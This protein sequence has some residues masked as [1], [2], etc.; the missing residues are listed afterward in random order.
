M[1]EWSLRL[2]PPRE[3]RRGTHQRTCSRTDTTPAPQMAP[4]RVTRMS[5]LDLPYE[6]Q[7]FVLAFLDAKSLSRVA[8]TCTELFRNQT[9]QVVDALCMHAA[10]HHCVC[11]DRL[12]NALTSWSSYLAFI[13]CRQSEAWV[14]VATG[15]SS[16]FFVTAGGCLSSCGSESA[17]ELGA[18]GHGETDAVG[19]M[20]MM[21]VLNSPTPLPSMIGIRIN[22]VSTGSGFCVAVSRCGIV[23][24][25]GNGSYGCLGH[26]DTNNEPSP[27][28]VQ[29]L[30]STGTRVLSVA[31]GHFHCLAITEG[32][33]VFSWGQ[34]QFGRCGY[35]VSS[36]GEHGNQS[37]QSRPRCVD[38]LIAVKARAAAAFDYHS[39]VVTELGALYTFGSGA[40][41]VDS[42]HVR[43]HHELPPTR[44]IA[45]RHVHITAAATG[46]KHALA[47]ANDGI[48]F[49]WG[50]N[51]H[52][53]LGTG[54]FGIGDSMPK[55]VVAMHGIAVV[56]ISTG[57][58]SSYAVDSNGELFTWGKGESG[59]LGHGESTNSCTPR[60]VDA[61]RGM[62]VVAVSPGQRNTTVTVMRDG[63]VFGWGAAIGFFL[64][65]IPFYNA[66]GAM[67]STLPCRYRRLTLL[68]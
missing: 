46:G 41:G 39:L 21:R 51:L 28:E 38:A 44:V 27:R 35:R 65:D 55:V 14:P 29:Y 37:V 4:D 67:C 56:S 17:A 10:V 1:Q 45:L 50:C 66:Y 32:G 33:A 9:N 34:S 42:K 63:S 8:A 47:L 58:G 68:R 20:M 57:F 18:L 40:H 23:Y 16:A 61:C 31:T 22:S 5:F 24:T 49:A 3:F 59:Q 43:D 26:G 11:P 2:L 12:P 60:R 13:E 64:P 54:C 30:A 25:W 48:V 52:G 19:D 15:L 7:V 53:Q 6:V 62:Y 36:R